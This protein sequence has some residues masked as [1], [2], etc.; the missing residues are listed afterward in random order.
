MEKQ[1][2]LGGTL[3][4]YH[5]R[6]SGF[7]QQIVDTGAAS[8][9]K[10]SLSRLRFASRLWFIGINHISGLFSGTDAPPLLRPAA[11]VS[12]SHET[13]CQRS[14]QRLCSFNPSQ[15]QRTWHLFISAKC[16]RAEERPLPRISMRG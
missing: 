12:S 13:L 15:S 1:N 2:P 3:R 7:H 11:P 4:C 8:G 5:V 10:S 6:L 9:T 16:S 14:L